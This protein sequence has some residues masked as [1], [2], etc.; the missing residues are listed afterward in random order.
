MQ[1]VQFDRLINEFVARGLE[2]E[3]QDVVLGL[4]G[5]EARGGGDVQGEPLVGLR[6]G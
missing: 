1:I 2:F 3:M 5:V 6:G 4:E